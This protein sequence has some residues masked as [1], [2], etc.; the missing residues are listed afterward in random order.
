MWASPANALRLMADLPNILIVLV[1]YAMATTYLWSWH[2]FL[3]DEDP[4][5]TP[6]ESA[7]AAPANHG[8]S[9]PGH[10]TLA[11]V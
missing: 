6:G 1:P 5:H 8:N 10:G 9:Q 7:Q 11:H 3:K 2:M 4:D